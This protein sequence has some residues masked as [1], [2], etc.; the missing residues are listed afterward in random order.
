MKWQRT[1]PITALEA[2]HEPEHDRLIGSS[3]IACQAALKARG[4]RE[5]RID[6]D[7]WKKPKIVRAR[8]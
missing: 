6:R 5:T 8:R 3:Y 2:E 4:E 7:P 1:T